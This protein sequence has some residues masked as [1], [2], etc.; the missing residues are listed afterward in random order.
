MTE[1][2][3]RS[4]GKDYAVGY[5]RPPKWGQFRKGK[6]GNPAGRPK[7]AKNKLKITGGKIDDVL[8]RELAR[9]VEIRGVDGPETLSILE[10]A[11]R[12]LSV[13]AMK[14]N[15]RAQEQLI[16]LQREIDARD[17]A[18]L[19]ARDRA[20]RAL[21]E[22]QL[23]RRRRNSER[24]IDEDLVPDPD[25]IVMDRATARMVIRGPADL[26][27]KVEW[28]RMWGAFGCFRWE[29][30]QARKKLA[31][32]RLRHTAERAY[33]INAIR[34]HE[35]FVMFYAMKLM[36]VFSIEAWHVTDDGF[37]QQELEQRLQEGRWPEPPADIRRR[38]SGKQ[39]QALHRGENYHDAIATQERWRKSGMPPLR[40]P[41]K[42]AAQ[43]AFERQQTRLSG[44][45]VEVS[46][47]HQATTPSDHGEAVSAIEPSWIDQF[48]LLRGLPPDDR[49]CLEAASTIVTTPAGE[50]VFAP[51]DAV[52]RI[53]FILSGQIRV[54]RPP[55]DGRTIQAF[56]LGSGA[57]SVLAVGSTLEV[58]EY[59][60]D[61]IAE[62]DVTSV[63]ISTE[64]FVDMFHRSPSFR[65]FVYE[66]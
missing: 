20:L 4:D 28:E 1:T 21:K 8:R 11:A 34:E 9:T 13:Q 39:L 42:P 33:L 36:S 56:L 62:F 45:G 25:H 53:F 51:G 54:Q 32:L 27:Q 64:T 46:S 55:E 5:G 7:G 18:E 19:D 14:G 16:K 43:E 15:V 49:A 3:S 23:A 47:A 50:R 58:E 17:A 61:G 35:Y 48:S 66:R 2:P 38:L 24:G 52:H 29:L 10:A 65:M 41:G 40:R 44:A 30:E 22:H 57:P 63:A 12:S 37:E 60:A 31:R 59:N 26:Q 6:S